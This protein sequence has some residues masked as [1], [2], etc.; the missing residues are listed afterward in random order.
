VGR[1]IA[2]AVAL[3][4]AG[5]TTQAGSI[6]GDWSGTGNAIIVGLG[7]NGAEQ[8]A[9]LDVTSATNIGGVLD[10]AG[11]LDVTG[12][13]YSASQCGTGGNVTA[14]GFLLPNGLIDFG[15]AGNPTGFVGSRSSNSITG[16][17]ASLNGDLYHWTFTSSPVAA[18]PEIDPAGALSGIA[19]LAGGIAL[20]RGRRREL[21]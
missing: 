11:T 7:G 12:V 1:S 19:L 16:L 13:G 21:R 3:C 9:N 2:C 20:I 6:L 17:F 18:A 14:S 4:L 10:F 8:L 5:V 15:V